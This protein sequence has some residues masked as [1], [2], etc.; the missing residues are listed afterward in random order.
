MFRRPGGLGRWT[1]LWRAAPDGRVA[2]HQGTPV[3]YIFGA[4]LV[5]NHPG[6]AR[7]AR[8]I[9]MLDPLVLLRMHQDRSGW[10]D[11]EFVR[12]QQVVGS[13]PTAGSI[14]LRYSN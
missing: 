9:V 12:N 3:W 8:P 11:L 4:K 7:P 10:S 6:S 13:I 1:I 5:P 14:Y 2:R